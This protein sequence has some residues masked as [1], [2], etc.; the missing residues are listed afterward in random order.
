M[1]SLTPLTSCATDTAFGQRIL[2]F[3]ATHA[4]RDA[5]PACTRLSNEKVAQIG[6]RLAQ[7][8]VALLLPHSADLE[9]VY[10]N[11]VTLA[12]GRGDS[13]IRGCACT[14]ISATSPNHKIGRIGASE[15][16]QSR[17][18]HRIAESSR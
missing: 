4:V 8:G 15:T 11:T 3:I 16:F 9:A 17:P 13:I 14:R 12:L 10:T 7:T 6:A 1:K 5:S 18:R 2:E